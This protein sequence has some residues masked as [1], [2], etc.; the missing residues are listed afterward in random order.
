MDLLLSWI[1]FS[2]DKNDWGLEESC[3]TLEN[4]SPFGS[5]MHTVCSPPDRVH[6]TTL[7]HSGEIPSLTKQTGNP[8]P[9]PVY[10][11]LPSSFAIR[12]IDGIPSTHVSFNFTI[13][14]GLP[15]W[16]LLKIRGP[17]TYVQYRSSWADIRK[18]LINIGVLVTW[19]FY[20]AN[21]MLQ[22]S[23]GIF[24]ILWKNKIMLSSPY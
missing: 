2:H 17:W 12:P 9:W 21:Q 14:S 15:R 1:S 19:F 4:V 13:I 6:L 24:S 18:W 7:R 23:P 16:K 10:S 20:M 8:M 3:A 5:L 11:N 22:K